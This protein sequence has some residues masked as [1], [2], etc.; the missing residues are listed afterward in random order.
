MQEEAHD[1]ERRMRG[2]RNEQKQ[3]DGVERRANPEPLHGDAHCE[4]PE[5]AGD[6]ADPEGVRRSK[7]DLDYFSLRVGHYHGTVS[8]KMLD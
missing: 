1:A 7:D 6:A 3:C 4:A 8:E 2:A 5:C